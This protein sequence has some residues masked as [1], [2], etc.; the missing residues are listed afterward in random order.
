M[1]R[2]VIRKTKNLK[3]KRRLVSYEFYLGIP[4]KTKVNVHHTSQTMKKCRID[5]SPSAISNESPAD[6]IPYLFSKDYLPTISTPKVEKVMRFSPK[7]TVGDDK[8]EV[9]KIQ[10]FLF[11]T[12]LW[13]TGLGM[14]IAELCDPSDEVLMEGELYRYKPG[15]DQVYIPRWCQLTSKVFRVYRNQMAAK[16]FAAKPVLAVPLYV[17]ENVRKSKFKAHKNSKVDAE[18]RILRQNQFE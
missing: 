16:G 9:V 3:D 5:T 15:L 8:E 4:W 18:F 1:K 17:I 10:R 12:D 6:P 14:G 13:F 11:G 7:K 2:H